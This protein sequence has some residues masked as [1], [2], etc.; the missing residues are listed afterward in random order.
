MK[1]KVRDEDAGSS[2]K[3]ATACLAATKALDV[4]TFKSRVK[5]SRD[6]PRGFCASLLVPA[7]AI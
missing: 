7:A 4:L 2:L 3:A 6:S 5:T 1:M